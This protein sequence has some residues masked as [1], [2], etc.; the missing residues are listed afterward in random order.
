MK[1]V[2]IHS[3]GLDS[4]VLLAQAVKESEHRIANEE[5]ADVGRRKTKV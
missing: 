5:I 1:V 2:V 3:G 4:G